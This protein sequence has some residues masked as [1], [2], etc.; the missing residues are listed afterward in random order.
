MSGAATPP[1]K[2]A[3]PGARGTAAAWQ[4]WTTAGRPSDAAVAGA[5]A[6]AGAA[7][8]VAAG[9]DGDGLADGTLVD[10]VLDGD[11]GMTDEERDELNNKIV[12]DGAAYAATQ[13]QWDTFNNL[14]W[15]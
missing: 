15:S 5:V 2:P 4:E 14:D 11:D 13:M 7:A 10:D 6:A 3:A 9:H 8:V 12:A 1:E